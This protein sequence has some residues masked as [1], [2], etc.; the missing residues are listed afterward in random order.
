MI[1]PVKKPLISGGSAAILCF[2][3]TIGSPCRAQEGFP[4]VS[5][6]LADLN[7]QTDSE[8]LSI[9]LTQNFALKGVD[10][11]VI[12]FDT[13]LGEI[14]IELLASDAPG[15]VQN[16]LN[17]VEDS[18]Y[19]NSVFHRSVADF[20]VQGGGFTI[21]DNVVSEIPTDDP[22]VNEF[23][24]SNL[25][26]TVAMAKLG[27]DPDSATSQ[28]FFNV[29]DNSDN[30]DNQNGGFTVFAR[31]IGSS[32]D[33]VDEINAL[34]TFDASA[35]LGGAFSDLPLL[36]PTLTEENMIKSM[37]VSVVSIYPDDSEQ[38]AILAFAAES[39]NSDLVSATID[40]STL[41][42]ATMGS[43]SG[44]ATITVTATD[45]HENS[46]DSSFAVSVTGSGSASQSITFDELDDRTYGAA[47]VS[48][49]ANAT[50]GLPVSFAVVSGPGLL[51]PDNTLSLTGP[52]AI[53]VSAS[54][55]GDAQFEAAPDVERNFTVSQP[56]SGAPALLVA[57]AAKLVNMGTIFDGNTY[58]GFE[59]AGETGSFS[60][61]AG[62]ITRISFL[63]A[64]GDLMFA[65]FGSDN[66]DTV[67][68]ITLE[69]F[70]GPAV[71]SPYLQ[72]G[73]VYA[74]GHPSFEIQNSTALT[75]VSFFSLGNDTS[76]VDVSLIQ[77][78]TLAG[79]VNGIA[80]IQ[81]LSI[82]DGST[83]V[84]GINAANANFSGSDG[85][86]GIDAPNVVVGA[87]LYV[88][89]IS[90]AGNAQPAIRVSANS[91]VPEILITGGDLTETIGD[92]QIDTNGVIYSFP[93]VATDGQR[94]I[95]NT[96]HRPDLGDGRLEPVTDTFLVNI[97]L[98]FVTDGQVAQSAQ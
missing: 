87:L 97:N 24:L 94:S 2:A 95:S 32:I 61:I 36:N 69:D 70:V 37:T 10:G 50:S 76:R 31:A 21:L 34:A 15:T 83:E 49:A 16:F 6:P 91:T 51:N 48:L 13:N 17:Y 11:Q 96:V 27:N 71:P 4:F 45:S 43:S 80:E 40:G 3:L 29:S 62:E 66:P 14:N 84:G 39:S 75:F 65:E 60:S 78:D 81:S 46:I 72:P 12:Q 89:D 90:P 38:S 79:S 64:G 44:S 41:Q 22:I 20:I 88:G 1:L 54:Q 73:T 63:D 5:S 47:R 7:V 93:F 74:K 67:L 23:S 86:V 35:S 56:T 26:G 77:D 28:F 19:S 30:L 57:G 92:F 42:I 33:V 68:I 25:R 98:Y 55:A 53:T 58:N 8:P 59:L 85:I 82:N 18:D 9:D 52:G